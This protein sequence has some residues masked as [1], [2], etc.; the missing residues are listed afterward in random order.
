MVN[1]D[2]AEL[3]KKLEAPFM[4]TYKGKEYHACKWLPK[5]ANKE[6]NKFMC[7]AYL[8]REQVISRLNDCFFDKWQFHVKQSTAG[9]VYSELSVLIDGEWITRSD[10]GLEYNTDKTGKKIDKQDKEKSALT[11][12]L[13]RCAMQFGIGLYLND[14]PNKFVPAIIG[15]NGKAQPCDDH[16]KVL[17]GDQLHNFINLNMSKGRGLLYGM[18]VDMPELWNREDIK[19]LWDDLK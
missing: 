18:L 15:S 13:K 3:R 11:D 14:M 1:T 5:Q 17:Y 10:V 9:A 7:I 6:G 19:K 16:K 2:L 4:Q 12:S 8:D